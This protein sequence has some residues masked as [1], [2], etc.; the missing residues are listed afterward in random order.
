MRTPQFWL[1]WMVLC[2]NVTAGIAVLAMASPMLQ[3]VFGGKLLG[4]DAHAILS[5]AAEDGD[6]RGGGGSRR[7]DQPVQQPRPHLLGVD[8]GLSRPQE[9]LFRVLRR[10]HGRSTRSL[11]TWGIWGWRSL[12]VASVCI[13]LTMYG[14]G[15][16]T[17]PAY[18]AD[19][20]GTQMVGAIHGRLITSW[21]V[22]GVVG[23]MIIASLRQTQLAAGVPKNLVYDNTLYIMAGFCSYGLI[24]NCARPPGEGQALYERGA[25]SRASGR[26]STRRHRRKRSRTPRGAAWARCWWVSSHGLRSA[27]PSPSASISHCKRRRRCSDR[28]IVILPRS[29]GGGGAK[30]RRGTSPSARCARSSPVR[31][32]EDE[33]CF[34]TL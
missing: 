32:G 16:A 21:S 4:L 18:L 15:F 13:I 33:F 24:C 17:I 6:R 26:C 29:Y 30:R 2:L 28:E 5:D 1:I 19:I 27:S 20:F 34:N 7:P 22:A 14:G 23:P 11:P 9:H 8:V 3:E 25:S 10:G 31:T 12:F